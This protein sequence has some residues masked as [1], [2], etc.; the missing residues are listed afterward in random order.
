MSELDLVTAFALFRSMDGVGMFNWR[1][2]FPFE[3]MPQEE[4]LYIA[5]KEHLWSLDKTV[6]KIPAELNIQAWDQDIF[7]PNEYISENYVLWWIC[8]QTQKILW[9]SGYF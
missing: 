9:F 7:K 8:L 6:T 1:F 3:Y 5:R 2:V 4:K